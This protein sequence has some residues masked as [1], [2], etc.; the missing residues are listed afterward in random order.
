[1]RDDI[2]SLVAES[3]EGSA[4][5]QSIVS[6][7]KDFAHLGTGEVTR[8]DVSRLLD[9]TLQV[10]W[11]QVKYKAE[12]RKDYGELPP[13]RCY[14][15]RLNQVFLNIL[16]NAVQAIEVHGVIT[17]AT[18]REGDTVSI[19]IADTGMGIPPEILGR[20]F[21]PFFTTKEAGKG[22]GLGLSVSYD[23]VKSHGGE[24]RVESTP[25]TGTA[26]TIILPIEPVF[27]EDAANGG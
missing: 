25:G 7:L 27:P 22:T 16:L 26:F 2:S 20:I 17:I 24:I 5:V 11:N 12:V 13:I 21:E 10:I 18:R 4:R 14:A 23:I 1:M 3:L 15:Q 9:A 6:S 19:R 8:A